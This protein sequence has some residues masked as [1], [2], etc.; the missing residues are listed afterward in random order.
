[1]CLDWNGEIIR[2]ESGAL[3]KAYSVED[4]GTGFPFCVYCFNVQPRIE[5][6]YRNEES[7]IISN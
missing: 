6:D 4:R 5:I 3:M 2:M 1:M 7:K